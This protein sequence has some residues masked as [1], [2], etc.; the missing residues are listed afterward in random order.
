M[1]VIFV[2]ALVWYFYQVIIIHTDCDMLKTQKQKE[3][4]NNNFANTRI[5]LYKYWMRIGMVIEHWWEEKWN[6]MW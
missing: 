3:K 5:C 1:T 2:I 6:S 4:K